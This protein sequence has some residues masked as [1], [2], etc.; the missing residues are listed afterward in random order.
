MHLHTDTLEIED[1]RQILID[2]GLQARGV[3]F[4]WDRDVKR[5]GSRKRDHKITFYLVA[6]PGHGRRFANTG[7][8]GA[9]YERA[10]LYDEWG[11][12]LG[13]IFHREPTAI[14]GPYNGAEEFL[15]LAIRY[16]NAETAAGSDNRGAPIEIDD[17]RNLYRP[18]TASSVSRQHYIDTGRYLTLSEAKSAP[19]SS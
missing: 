2:T 19:V 1:L 16:R 3:G 9:G 17:W 4:D 6:T 10:A 14:A 7:N 18:D 12:F 15:D 8:Y 11:A 13:E 5:S